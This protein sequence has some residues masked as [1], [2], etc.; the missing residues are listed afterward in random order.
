MEQIYQ[1]KKHE[2]DELINL[3]NLTTESIEQKAQDIYKKRG[4]YGINI[5][6]NT[7]SDWSG[8]ISFTAYTYVKDWDN[9]FPISM[10]DKKKIVKFIN[11][12]AYEFMTT[13]YGT[14]IK[15][16]NFYTA[17]L[18]SLKKTKTLFLLFTIIGWVIALILTMLNIN[19]I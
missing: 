17:E 2:Y 7:K 13:K 8:M 11:H 3:A 16:V 1:L 14:Q 19:T 10:E 18:K 4:T 15:N 5:E 6:I 12:R 9:K